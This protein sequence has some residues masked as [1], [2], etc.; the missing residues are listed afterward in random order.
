MTALVESA[1]A[2]YESGKITK[3]QLISILKWAL[4]HK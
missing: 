1:I 3:R 2:R 4:G